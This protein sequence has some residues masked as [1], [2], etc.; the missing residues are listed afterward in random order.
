VID[1]HCHL[2]LYPD[3]QAVAQRCV[4]LGMYVLSV[5]TTPSAWLGTKQLA[6]S[7]SRIRTGLGL[8]PQLAHERH[9]EVSLFSELLS[10]A[11]YVGEIG[12]DG[13]PEF[14]S[15]WEIQLRVFRS[16]LETC[17]LQ[18]RRPASIH[19]RRATTAVLDELERLP[20]AVTPV[21][22]WFSG[23]PKELER[24]IKLGCWFS[25]GPGMLASAKGR[26]LVAGMPAMKVLTE[27][28]GPFARM[29]GGSAAMP[30][31]VRLA[32][33]ALADVWGVPRD[34]VRSVIQDNLRALLRSAP[35][36]TGA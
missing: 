21:L 31:D 19:G 20:G 10:E 6:P 33:D 13:G 28:D 5:T 24:A 15:S 7:G 23:T 32:E 17:A 34:A 36:G 2:D 16:I 8:H 1:L 30:W 29:P 11:D 4:A 27:T 9:G 3:P 14:R 26:M 12:L 18:R 35:P 25:V 22:H